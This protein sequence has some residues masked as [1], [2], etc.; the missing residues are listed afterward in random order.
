MKYPSR[1][2]EIDP[3]SVLLAGAELY[4][5]RVLSGNSNPSTTGC[6]RLERVPTEVMA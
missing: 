5:P 4:L 3:Q 6:E 2:A 1:L